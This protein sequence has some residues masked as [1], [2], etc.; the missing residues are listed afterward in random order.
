[1]YAYTYYTHINIRVEQIVREPLADLKDVW[2]SLKSGVIL[3]RLIN[4]IKPKLIPKIATKRLLPLVEQ[5]NI[6]LF[7]TA[8]SSLGVPRDRIF[9]VSDLHQSKNLQA[10]FLCLASLA[11]RAVKLNNQLPGIEGDVESERQSKRSTQDTQPGV[12]ADRKR[13]KEREAKKWAPVETK[14]RKV[15]VDDLNLPKAE[16]DIATLQLQVTI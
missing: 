2:V 8:C 4:K 12:G 13:A 14:P 5:S 10:V 16:R 15:F 11:V 9:L 1:M 7:L 3:C 6:Q